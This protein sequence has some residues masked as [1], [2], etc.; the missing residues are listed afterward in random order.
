[1]TPRSSH[2]WFF[3]KELVVALWF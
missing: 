2:M 3:I 1:V